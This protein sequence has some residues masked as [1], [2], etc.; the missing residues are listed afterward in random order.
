MRDSKGPVLA[1]CGTGLRALSLYAIAQV[2]DGH[3]ALADVPALGQR[4]GMDLTHT[5]LFSTF[6]LLGGTVGTAVGG[7]DIKALR[8]QVV[9]LKMNQ[10]MAWI[11]NQ[12]DWPDVYG[13]GPESI[14]G[15]F[16]TTWY[17]RLDLPGVKELVAAYQKNFPGMAIAVPGFL[18]TAWLHDDVRRR[19]TAAVRRARTVQEACQALQQ[20]QRPRPV[21]PVAVALQ[22]VLVAVAGIDGSWPAV[23]STTAD[24]PPVAI[25]PPRVAGRAHRPRPGLV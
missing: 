1:H 5:A 21:L 8:Q 3:L 2:M 4:Y 13:L 12:Q 16:G 18:G 7:D 19:M 6:V 25:S 9:Q 14:F 20:Q 15:V 24:A 10:S 11:N 17:Y 23:S 22:L